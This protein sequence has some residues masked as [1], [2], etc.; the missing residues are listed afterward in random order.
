[1]L[2]G[3]ASGSITELSVHDWYLTLNRPP[4]TPPQGVFPFVWLPLYVL[5]GVA[6]WRVARAPFFLLSRRQQA[7]RAWGWQLI[8]NALWSPAFFGLESP[9]A[10]LLVMGFLIGALITV[11]WHFWPIDRAAGVFLLP[12]LLW[13]LYAAYLNAGF[14]W[15]N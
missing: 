11:L 7:L 4:G 14:W 2:V 5:S 1:V 10:G 3:L 12:Y 13:V 9:L 6:A 15:L 8:F